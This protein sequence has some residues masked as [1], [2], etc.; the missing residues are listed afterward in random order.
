[1]FRFLTV[2]ITR[3]FSPELKKYRNIYSE[4]KTLT[5]SNIVNEERTLI[6]IITIIEVLYKFHDQ[7]ISLRREH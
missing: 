4:N 2:Y 7:I 1:M 5:L 6:L 3:T